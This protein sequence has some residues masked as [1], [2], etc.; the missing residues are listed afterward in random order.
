MTRSD[1]VGKSTKQNM[2]NESVLQIIIQTLA[3][4]LVYALRKYV[5]YARSVLA[6]S[7]VELSQQQ[8]RID[9]LSAGQTSSFRSLFGNEQRRG[10]GRRS[11]S[12][13]SVRPA[14]DNGAR[15]QI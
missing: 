8:Q 3:I 4:A 6:Q 14:P 13:G 5:I 12:Q 11:L 10:R 9:V 2:N 7:D 15:E 1:L